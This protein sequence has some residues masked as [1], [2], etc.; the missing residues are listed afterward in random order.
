MARIYVDSKTYDVDESENLLQACLSVGIDIP[1]FCW[2]PLMGSLGACRQCA[3]TQYNDFEDCKGRLIMSCMTPV[4]DGMIISVND[5]ES[6]TFRSSIIELLLTNHPHDCPICEEGGH[7]HLQDM[8]VMTKHNVR[9]FRFKKRTY[10]N[11]YLGSFIKHEMNRC[12]AC[13]RCVRYYNDYADGTDFGVYGCNNNLYFGRIENGGLENEHSGNLIELCPTGVFTDNTHSKKYNRK[14]D[15]QYAPGICHNCSVGCNI[16]IGERYGEIRRIENRYH[17]NIN[18][19]LI[20]DLGRF[21]YSHTSL[22]KRPKKPVYVNSDNSMILNFQEAIE[23]GALFFEKYSRVIGVGSSRS[24]IENNFALQELVGK[25]NFSHG[26]TKKEEKCITIIL[27]CLKNSGLYSPNLKE[28]E[29]YD[30]ILVLGEDLTQTSPR[31]ALA[32]R[33][34]MKKK[35]HD[36]AN[37]HQIPK[38]NS[39]PISQ[40]VEHHKNSLYIIHTHE[41]KLDDV[42]EWSY[43]ASIHE[44]VNFSYAIACE[45]DEKLPKLS[46]LSVVLKEKVSTIANRLLSSKKAL[47]ISGSHSFSSSI[48]KSAINI[49][50]SIKTRNINHHVGLAFLTSS[51]NSLGLSLIGGISIDTVLKQFKEKKVDAV[52]FMEYDI[53]RFL[54]KYDCDFVFKNKKKIITIDHQHT[55]TYEKSGLKLP[56]TNFTE[57]SG[58]IVNFEAR[59][60]RFFQVYDP[61]FYDNRNCLHESWKWLHYIKSKINKTE[62]SWFNLDDVINAC[63]EKYPIFKKIKNNEKNANFR[64]HGQKISRSPNRSSGRTALRA[65]INIHEP[66]QP[67]DINTM[68]SFSME[69]YNQ[70]H[71]CISHIPFAWFPGWNSP[72]A[73][74]KFQDKIGKSLIS[75]NSG[76][77]L[78][79]KNKIIKN[80]SFIPIL[81]N[82]M[83]EKYWYIIP[84][85]H[86]YGN[87]ELT[88]YSL[89]IQENIPEAYALISL[90]DS[91][92]L[93]LNK[94]ST[95][96]FHCLKQNYRLKIRISKHLSSKQIGL[97]VGRKSFPISLIGQKVQ[98]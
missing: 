61:M 82:F 31:V 89:I 74:N 39:T 48:I 83:K 67:K 57:T 7:C 42:A 28:I 56:A 91:I 3:V 81:K 58:T 30:V 92:K 68:F 41:T 69:G 36:M 59:A 54:S 16:S 18:H 12:I 90:V 72:Q 85:Y 66:E 73:W 4:I 45:L 86:I 5:I 19:Y 51:C 64:I 47:I 25:S 32:I 77:H 95:L 33:Q 50:T 80:F 79:K 55:E 37:L 75:G 11:Q 13:Y 24:S 17:Q 14:W 44:Q 98:L 94:D 20:C 21:G 29:S 70:P 76:T 84:Y 87:E 43:F 40:I 46:N 62:I 78:F 10:K 2:H 6:K 52:I 96:Q 23:L 8:A 93:G 35:A 15:M 49:A 60:Q 88:Q 27:D 65:D 97:P 71:K 9:N 53:Y 26:M 22:S 34:A 1:Y 63:I 38:W